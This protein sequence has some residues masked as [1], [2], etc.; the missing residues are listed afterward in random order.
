MLHHAPG[1]VR[2]GPRAAEKEIQSA[3]DAIQQLLK[4]MRPAIPDANDLISLAIPHKS[5]IEYHR[6]RSRELAQR[7]QTCRDQ[8]R[9]TEL[10]LNR[11]RKEYERTACDEHAV[12]AGELQR[13]PWRPSPP[14]QSLMT[15]SWDMAYHSLVESGGVEP[16]TIR[17]PFPRAVTNLRA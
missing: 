16:P 12:P 9:N 14:S 10:L 2:S 8:I 5:A 17:P 4:S 15:L 11:H 3:T 1:P 7:R 6:D 13:Q